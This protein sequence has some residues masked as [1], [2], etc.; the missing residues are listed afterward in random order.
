MIKQS[1]NSIISIIGEKVPAN[2]THY[3][4]DRGAGNEVMSFFTKHPSEQN[5]R[6]TKKK[7]ILSNAQQIIL[8]DNFRSSENQNGFFEYGAIREIFR[9]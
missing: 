5:P 1:A 7:V 8:H 3:R 9:G 6:I 4:I 2:A